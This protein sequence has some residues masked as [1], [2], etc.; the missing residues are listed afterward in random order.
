LTITLPFLLKNL[1]SRRSLFRVK[2]KTFYTINAMKRKD[3]ER[4][5]TICIKK[6]KDFSTKKRHWTGK[7]AHCSTSHKD[8]V[9]GNL[10]V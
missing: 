1:L 9:D 10:M 8:N 7:R 4:K 2:S 3:K 6:E 5:R